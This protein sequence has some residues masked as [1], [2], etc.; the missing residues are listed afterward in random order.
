MASFPAWSSFG[1][2]S[3]SLSS[4]YRDSSASTPFSRLGSVVGH[5]YKFICAIVENRMREVMNS[6]AG[7]VVVELSDWL[8]GW[9]CYLEPDSPWSG[10]IF[11]YWYSHLHE[12]PHQADDLL[13]SGSMI[14]MHSP[15]GDYLPYRLPLDPCY[16]DGR[17]FRVATSRE[18]KV[19]SVQGG[20]N[21][22]QVLWWN[23]RS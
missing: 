20:S 5:R 12:C 18:C 10:V 8:K 2:S 4:R 19:S 9:R 1:S 17:A 11:V 21:R 3:V 23:E 7:T 16:E 13:P 6:R 14:N 15:I 22:P